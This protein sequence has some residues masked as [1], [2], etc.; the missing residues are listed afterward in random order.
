MA[1]VF[2]V[3]SIIAFIISVA[4]CF[5][6][7]NKESFEAPSNVNGIPCGG[8]RTSSGLSFNYVELKKF[9]LTYEP[10]AKNC[11]IEAQKL[12]AMQYSAGEVQDKAIYWKILLIRIRSQ[13]DNKRCIPDRRYTSFRFIPL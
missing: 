4:I 2:R 5:A 13:V 7:E 3:I 1:G 6:D 10:L 11:D 12:L 8:N 9:F